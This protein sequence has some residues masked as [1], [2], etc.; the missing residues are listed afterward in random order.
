M[1]L[2]NGLVTN[3]LKL[4]ILFTQDKLLF[5]YIDWHKLIDVLDLK[6][7]V[8]LHLPKGYCFATH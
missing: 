6:V 5:G 1:F 4:F 7:G 8:W 2:L 3:R